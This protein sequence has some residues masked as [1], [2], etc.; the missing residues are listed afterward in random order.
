MFSFHNYTRQNRFFFLAH[1]IHTI[2]MSYYY[3]VD[4]QTDKVFFLNASIRNTVT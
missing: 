4:K 3:Y 1:T 2:R